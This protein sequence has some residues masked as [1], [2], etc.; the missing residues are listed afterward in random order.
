MYYR[1][2]FTFNKMFNKYKI[3][4]PTIVRDI[5]LNRNENTYD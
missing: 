1:K 3:V 4:V 2:L 5:L